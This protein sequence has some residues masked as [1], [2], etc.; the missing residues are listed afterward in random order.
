MLRYLFAGYSNGPST[1]LLVVKM[2]EPNN[3]TNCQLACSVGGSPIFPLP[4]GA[5]R[6]NWIP[7]MPKW[8]FN[9][10][11]T[12]PSWPRALK[13]VRRIVA[14]DCWSVCKMCACQKSAQKTLRGWVAQ[15]GGSALSHVL[16]S[17]SSNWCLRKL[18]NAFPPVTWHPQHLFF[19][20]SSFHSAFSQSLFFWGHI[21]EAQL[22]A[23]HFL[24][25]KLYERVGVL[26]S[27]NLN[28]F[29][30]VKSDRSLMNLILFNQA[31]CGVIIILIFCIS[32]GNYTRINKVLPD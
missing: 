20:F 23:M 29:V 22:N 11:P 32:F 28:K 4:P 14:T 8:N 24:L 10:R 12:L 18:A 21:A 31:Q 15:K 7:Q 26:V 16:S 13:K 9:L 5:T 30:V 3:K 2:E 25:P 19:H 6:N 17:L 27:V 1:Q